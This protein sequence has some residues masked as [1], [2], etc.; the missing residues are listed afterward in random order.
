MSQVL[1][2]PQLE[3]EG[4]LVVLADYGD[5]SHSLDAK[6]DTRAE[7]AVLDFSDPLSTEV[8]PRILLVGLRRSGK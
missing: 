2:K 7:E 1:R 6:P 3:E 4:E 8:K 5:G